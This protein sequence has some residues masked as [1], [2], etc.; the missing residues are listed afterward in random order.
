MTI[1]TGM[2]ELIKAYQVKW[3]MYILEIGDHFKGNRKLKNEG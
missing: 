2:Q 1:F 3:G